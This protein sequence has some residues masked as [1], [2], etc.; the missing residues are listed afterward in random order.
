MTWIPLDGDLVVLA[1]QVETRR[2]DWCARGRRARN[3]PPRGCDPLLTPPPD[4]D[5]VFYLFLQ[6]QKIAL[7]PYTLWVLLGHCNYGGLI[8]TFFTD[9]EGVA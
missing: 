6:K 2:C 7:K 4:D 5:D 9:V 3:T 1:E 8:D